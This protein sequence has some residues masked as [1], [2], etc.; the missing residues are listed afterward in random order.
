MSPIRV[1]YIMGY[2]RS[3][4]TLLDTILGDHPEVES[5]GE[6]ANLLRAWSNDEFCACQR[7]AHK[8][9]FWQ[10]VWQRWEA[11]GEAGPEGYEELQERYQRLRQLPRLALASLLSS[12]TLEDYRCKTKGLF[13]AVAAVSGKKVIVDSSKNPG[14]G[15]V[16][17]GIPGL[18]VRL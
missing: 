8:C 4:S 15:L 5:V 11:S 12:K 9:P 3:G 17:A 18:D 1:L 14:R 7:R 10:E 16:L 6:L 2:G 13:E